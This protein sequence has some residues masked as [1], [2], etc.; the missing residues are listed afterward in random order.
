MPRLFILVGFLFLSSVEAN[1][2]SARRERNVSYTFYEEAYLEDLDQKENVP[3]PSSTARYY[4]PGNIPSVTVWKSFEHLQDGFLKMRDDKFLV[5]KNEPTKKRRPTWLYPDDG[6]Y[7]R[8]AMVS[9]SAAKL[10]M[11]IPNKIFA[12]GNLRVKTENS[13]YGSVGWW[14]HVASIVEVNG[15]K[16]VIDPAIDYERPLLL[17]E[18]LSRMGQP[19][20]IRVAICNSGTVIPGSNC[21]RISDGEERGSILSEQPYLTYEHA[22]MERLGRENEI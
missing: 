14:Y 18:W 11:P 15:E 1:V 19:D 6:C 13:T 20:K 5:W 9:R 22:R 17:I 4:K 12:F 10:G 3:T 21:T 7:A 16:Y 8:A 2:H